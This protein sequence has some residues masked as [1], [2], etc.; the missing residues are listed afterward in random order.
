[1]GASLEDTIGDQDLC[2]DQ[3][4]KQEKSDNSSPSVTGSLEVGECE[5]MEG[6]PYS[7]LLLHM[8]T[9]LIVVRM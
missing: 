4:H 8:L 2:P 5:E 9:T 1:M 7:M 6:D 3:G